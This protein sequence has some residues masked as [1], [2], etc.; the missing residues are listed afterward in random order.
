[1]K[2]DKERCLAA[3]MDGYVSKPIDVEQLLAVI[4]SVLG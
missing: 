1:M 4:E 2:G 3:G